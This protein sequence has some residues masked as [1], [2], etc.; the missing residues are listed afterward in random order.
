MNFKKC[1][2]SG[3][4]IKTIKK[5]LSVKK[6]SK[7]FCKYEKPSKTYYNLIDV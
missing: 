5:T 2:K 3:V 7:I 1:K 6:Q 4:G